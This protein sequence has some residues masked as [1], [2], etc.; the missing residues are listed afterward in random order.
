MISFEDLKL[1]SANTMC[2]IV[3]GINSINTNLQSILF[4]ATILYTVIRIV[5]EVRDILNK[6]KDK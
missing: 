2:M 5:N 1:L 3:L 4:L 6:K